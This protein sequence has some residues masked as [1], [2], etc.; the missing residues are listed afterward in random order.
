MSF[1]D[2]FKSKK[3][4][5]KEK[6][7]AQ[8]A[9]ERKVERAIDNNNDRIGELKKEQKTAWEQARLQLQQGNRPAAERL[10]MQYKAIGVNIAKFEKQMTWAKNQLNTIRGAVDT[11]TTAEALKNLA[12]QVELSP[13]DVAEDIAAVD[14][15]GADIKDIGKEMDK[16]FEKDHILPDDILW[17]QKAAFSDA[18]GHS[19]VDGLKAYAERIISDDEFVSGCDKYSHGR[20]FT[21]ESLLYRRLFEKHYPGQGEMIPDFWMPNRSW[22]GCNVDDPSARVLKNYGASGI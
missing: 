20:P 13:E 11:K 4:I 18:V 19:M 21:K 16:A 17:R 1:S 3:E 7:K 15:I 6:R 12:G 8:R 10:L 2:L 22:E 14:D 5:E 9:E